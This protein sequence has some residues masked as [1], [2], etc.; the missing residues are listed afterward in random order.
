MEYKFSH[1]WCRSGARSQTGTRYVSTVT[2]GASGTE[3]E[4]AAIECT[5]RHCVAE[6]R[7]T[8][9]IVRART[10]FARQLKAHSEMRKVI[11]PYPM[12]AIQLDVC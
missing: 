1:V 6:T 8:S 2:S 12:L 10:A 7:V 4:P 11:F 3:T 9:P 5:P